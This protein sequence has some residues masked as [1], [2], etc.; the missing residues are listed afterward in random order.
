[1]APALRRLRN[2]SRMRHFLVRGASGWR[3]SQI[4]P[5]KNFVAKQP[6]SCHV[7]ILVANPDENG[8]EKYEFCPHKVNFRINQ[9]EYI[10]WWDF[11][12][13]FKAQLILDNNKVMDVIACKGYPGL[14]AMLLATLLVNQL[15]LT[16]DVTIP[17]TQW[18]LIRALR[19]EN[20]VMSALT[21]WTY[22]HFKG[23]AIISG[24]HTFG[25]VITEMK[26]IKRG[27]NNWAFGNLGH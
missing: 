20:S 13:L 5:A 3:L 18:A 1:M 16:E 19:D 9:K 21:H 4:H 26:F 15:D 12:Q 17:S 22:D 2:A 10:H 23:Q 25:M 14:P 24:I 11:F 27:Y 7:L 6:G 8:G